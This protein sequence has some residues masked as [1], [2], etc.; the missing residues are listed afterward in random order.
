M[1][2]EATATSRLG[3]DEDV[4]ATTKEAVAPGVGPRTR[5]GPKAEAG[6]RARLEDEGR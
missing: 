3:L 1:A 2:T 6:P 5:A 4:R